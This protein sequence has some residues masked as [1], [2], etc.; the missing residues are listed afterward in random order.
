MTSRRTQEDVKARRLAELDRLLAD[1]RH[2][3]EYHEARKVR[4]IRERVARS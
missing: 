4:A 1:L 2:R 3:R